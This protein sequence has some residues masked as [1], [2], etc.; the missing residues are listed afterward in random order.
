MANQ[1]QFVASLLATGGTQL[2]YEIFEE[3]KHLKLKLL[4][5]DL[6]IIH[7]FVN[8]SFA[9]HKDCK[10]CSGAMM[11]LRKGAVSASSQLRQ[12]SLEAMS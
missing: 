6:R 1:T 4:A 10:G 7:W 3:Y 2:S 12:S 8:S 11:I 9:V 5:D